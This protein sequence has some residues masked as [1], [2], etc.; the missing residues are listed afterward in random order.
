MAIPRPQPH[1]EHMASRLRCICAK[2][3]TYV[4]QLKL[5][6]S[7]DHDPLNTTGVTASESRAITRWP[8][9]FLL[10]ATMIVSFADRTILA[11]MVQPIKAELQLTDT[12][13][14]LLTGF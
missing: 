9:L 11:L 1:R 12:E 6:K 14:G 10:T 3:V 5:G 13:I 8:L 2:G 7:A 4:Q